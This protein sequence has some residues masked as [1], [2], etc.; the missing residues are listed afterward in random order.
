MTTT[1]DRWVRAGALG[2]TM[3]L[4][5]SALAQKIEAP[6]YGGT[7]EVATIFATLSALSWDHKDWP[8]KINHDAGGIYEQLLT[9]D[10]SKGTRAGGKHTFH[11]DAWLPSDAI[12]GE[13]A[14][15][16]EVQK[17]P[18]AVVIKLKK[19]IMFP[20]KPGVWKRAS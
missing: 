20:A 12:K 13:L 19:G 2:A 1:L 7:L 14:E 5:G 17:E 3:L 9:A 10:L 16:W 18:L 8:W 4:S 11:A 6:K 15:S